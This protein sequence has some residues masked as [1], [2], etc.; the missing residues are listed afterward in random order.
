MSATKETNAKQITNPREFVYPQGTNIEIQGY[1]L[2]DLIMI[3]E[4][5]LTEE[6]KVESKFKYNYVNEKGNIV[7]TPKAADIESG[8]VVKQLDFNRTVMDPNLEYSI[9]EKGIAYAELKNF[10]ESIH[11]KNIQEGK[12]VSY[13]ELTKNLVVEG[14]TEEKKD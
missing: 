7:K 8:K 10:L 2:T 4:K 5:L 1:L 13:A 3:F 6:V 11:F 14:N 12:A 9:T